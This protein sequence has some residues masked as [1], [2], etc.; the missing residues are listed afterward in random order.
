MF[1]IPLYSI[2]SRFQ[3]FYTFWKL[4][5]CFWVIPRRQ[6]FMCRRFGSLCAIFIGGVSRKSNRDEIV[7]V[8][9]GK[10]F[11]SKIACANRK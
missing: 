8:L 11:G 2:H 4:Y 9:Y 3:T 7:G 10:R 5:S 1:I 6:N